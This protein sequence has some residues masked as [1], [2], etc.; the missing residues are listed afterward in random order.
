MQLQ[1]DS[2]LQFLGPLLDS[3]IAPGDSFTAAEEQA[4]QEARDGELDFLAVETPEALLAVRVLE[5]LIA[6][7]DRLIAAGLVES[8]SYRPA[9]AKLARVLQAWGDAARDVDDA[10]DPDDVNEWSDKGRNADRNKLYIGGGAQINAKVAS[11]PR[12]QQSKHSRILD[13]DDAR[14]TWFV[15]KAWMEAGMQ[16]DARFKLTTAL[17]DEIK[18]LLL[19]GGVTGDAF[20]AA[21]ADKIAPLGTPHPLWHSGDGR[22]TY[23]AHEIAMLLDAGYLFEEVD[24]ANHP[25]EKKQQ[26]V[27]P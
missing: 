26:F 9:R 4:C 12:K 17:T 25:G 24:R 10:T 8:R 5:Q 23:F 21:V 22:A 20:L 13:V 1:T 2:A 11:N 18:A 19:A 14:W 7:I 27:R 16:N 3:G 6:K 15:N